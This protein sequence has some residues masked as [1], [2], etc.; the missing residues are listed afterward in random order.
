MPVNPSL[1][2]PYWMCG[3]VVSMM[4]HNLWMSV[5]R[6]SKPNERLP[7]FPLARNFT[8]VDEYW[9]V[10]GTDSRMTYIRRTK[11]YINLNMP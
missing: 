8:I 2:K 10:P 9:M 4:I 6:E 3:T 5:M 7:L 11:I 1:P